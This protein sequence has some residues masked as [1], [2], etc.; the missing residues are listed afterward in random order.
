[1]FLRQRAFK[2]AIASASGELCIGFSALFSCDSIP[3]F[4]GAEVENTVVY[5]AGYNCFFFTAQC[6]ISSTARTFFYY[7]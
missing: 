2:V 7:H 5:L 4:V 1:M 3:E 6:L